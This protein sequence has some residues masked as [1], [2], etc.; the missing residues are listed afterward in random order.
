[1][2]KCKK[3][4]EECED[5]YDSCWS[6]GTGRDGS[7]LVEASEPD[8]ISPETSPTTPSARQSKGGRRSVASRYTD[9]YLIARATT[10]FGA[11]VKFIAIAIGIGI[12]LLA[13]LEGSQSVQIGI[14]G[15]VLGIIVAIPIYILGILVTAQG[16]IL[17][18]TLDT[19]VNSSPLLTK[20]EMRE[21]MSL[22]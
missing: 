7:T 13:L 11:T 16:Q 3:C 8:S 17:K 6:C 15:V 1:M 19:A 4:K 2:W 12:A 5:N 18:A 14:C 21:I 10:A 20:D 9:A 22:D